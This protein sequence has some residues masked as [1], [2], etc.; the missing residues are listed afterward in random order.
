[1]NFSVQQMFPISTRDVYPL[2]SSGT[3]LWLGSV[4]LLI[5]RLS[6]G[7]LVVV[8]VFVVISGVDSVA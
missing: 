7:G 8:V 5:E 1:M 6:D 3:L 2:V 4:G